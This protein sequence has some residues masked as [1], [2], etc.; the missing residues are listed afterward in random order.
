MK[1]ILSLSVICVLLTL[2]ARA[3]EAVVDSASVTE[4]TEKDSQFENTVTVN[5]FNS[6]VKTIRGIYNFL[7]D[8]GVQIGINESTPA[9]TLTLDVGGRIGADE[10][11]DAEGENCIDPATWDERP[12]LELQPPG[13]N[14]QIRYRVKDAK[15]QSDWQETG[16]NS[17]SIGQMAKFNS[18]LAT[19]CTGEGCGVQMSL[20][21][22]PNLAV[23]ESASCRIRYRLNHLK[24]RTLTPWATTTNTTG[25]TWADGEWSTVTAEDGGW[26]DGLNLQAGIECADNIL[27]CQLG[28]K[29]HNEAESPDWKLSPFT[30]GSGWKDGQTS[31]LSAD[32][33]RA[34]DK[35][36]GCGLQMQTQC[37]GTA[38]TLKTELFLCPRE[39]DPNCPSLCEGQ[40]STNE[41]CTYQRVGANN[42]CNLL[43]TENCEPIG[44][45]V[46]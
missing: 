5:E 43:I 42:Q 28:Y 1:K 8:T 26:G 31:L 24:Q 17:D 29:L 45:L 20:K 10:Y 34:C 12:Q 18:G 7:T 22:S 41:N 3:Q 19:N 13:A 44:H 37:V 6:L 4:I 32:I 27:R 14:C 9:S 11:C 16:L 39:R 23:T 46:Q 21:C 33:G 25:D 2:S 15:Y 35:R 30:Q 36:V 40:I 38:S